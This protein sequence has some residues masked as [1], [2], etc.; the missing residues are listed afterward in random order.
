[1]TSTPLTA[2]QLAAIK[3]R[4]AAATDGPWWNDGHEIYVGEHMDIPAMCTWI[5]E[6]CA[7][8]LPDY[9]AANGAFIA[10]A[11]QDIPALLAEL[12]RARAELAAV[13]AV[14]DAAEHQATRWEDP[15]PVPEWVTQ[16]RNAA[17][18][19]A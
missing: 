4:E 10:H 9:G 17:R 19:G 13:L 18:P 12:D 16:V 14:C 8:D 1:V 11:R 15:L 5:G 6:T 7:V 2:E 3:A